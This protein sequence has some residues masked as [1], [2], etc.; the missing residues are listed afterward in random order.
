MQMHL[1]SA[2]IVTGALFIATRSVLM[3]TSKLQAYPNGAWQ[4]VLQPLE[5]NNHMHAHQN[6][7]KVEDTVIR[8]NVEFVKR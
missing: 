6:A 3:R 5:C 2:E 7:H 1:C 4:V 8:E